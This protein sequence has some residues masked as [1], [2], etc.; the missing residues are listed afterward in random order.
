MFE[1]HSLKEEIDQTKPGVHGVVEKEHKKKLWYAPAAKQPTKLN[2]GLRRRQVH[3]A[4]TKSRLAH[5]FRRKTM[6]DSKMDVRKPHVSVSLWC[7]EFRRKRHHLNIAKPWCELYAPTANNRKLRTAT[8]TPTHSRRSTYE[9]F[10]CVWGGAS[11]LLRSL[12]QAVSNRSTR[13]HP[14]AQSR[15]TCQSP[16]ALFFIGVFQDL[17][18]LLLLYG[19]DSG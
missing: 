3:T 19:W 17:R 12:R 1:L 6:T 13:R 18:P 8:T 16:T 7:A 15:L 14:R 9:P 5:C 11:L 2:F 10:V 4:S